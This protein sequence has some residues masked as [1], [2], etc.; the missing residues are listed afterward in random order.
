[1][2]EVFRRVNPSVVIIR[3]RSKEVAGRV[4]EIGSGFLISA[5]GKVITASHV[6]QI[7]DEI[8]AEFLGGETIPAKVVAS[9]PEADVACSSSSGHWRSRSS[10]GWATP[11]RCRWAIRS[12][13]SA[14]PTASGTRS[15]W[16][17]S[18]RATSP[19]YEEI[20]ERLSALP[21]GSLVRLT[22]LR[23]GQQVE[24]SA[25]R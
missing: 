19:G 6:V 20:Q 10:R 17:M 22:V 7:A 24:L 8:T 3:A 13:S 1:V 11:T 21:A 9:E 5:D 16:G 12:S 14:R 18:A 2:G 15:A 25:P 23:D 4:A